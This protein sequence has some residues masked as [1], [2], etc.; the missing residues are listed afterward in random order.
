VSEGYSITINSKGE[1]LE[2]EYSV[3]P[4]P[5][6][7][8]SADIIPKFKEKP[9]NLEALFAGGRHERVMEP[10]YIRAA[11]V[12]E[13]VEVASIV[14]RIAVRAATPSAQHRPEYMVPK[15]CADTIVSGRKSVMALMMPEKRQRQFI[16]TMMR[17][18][19]HEQIPGIGH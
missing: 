9:I 15:C 7:P 16:G 13:I 19:V 8:T 10:R 17:A 6:Q 1:S 11:D 12:A 14:D 4:S 5:A 18:V 2:T 3:V